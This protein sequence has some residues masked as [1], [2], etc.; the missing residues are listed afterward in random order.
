MRRFS[1]ILMDHFQSPR[2]RRRLVEADL[3]GIGGEPGNGATIRLALHL[4]GTTIREAAFESDG[5]GVT[6]ACGSILTELVVGRTIAECQSLTSQDV[7]G[8]L[9]GLPADKGHS[10]VV[11]I[12]ALQSACRDNCSAEVAS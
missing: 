3:V 6:I 2:N 7:I 5:C 12:A 10:A 9:G 1:E 4:D 11:A 8:A